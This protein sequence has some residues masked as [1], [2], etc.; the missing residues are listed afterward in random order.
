M[1]GVSTFE[2]VPKWAV[3]L[4]CS[5]LQVGNRAWPPLPLISDLDQQR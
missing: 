3:A 2:A 5:M 1:V 4:A